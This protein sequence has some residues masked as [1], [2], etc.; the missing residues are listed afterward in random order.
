MDVYERHR[1]IYEINPD[2]IDR[3]ME[4]G[5]IFTGMDIKKD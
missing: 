4:N 5:L 3:F 2:Y 1:H